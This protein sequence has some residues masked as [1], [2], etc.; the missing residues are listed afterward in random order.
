MIAA[1]SAP[2]YID[3]VEESLQTVV[4]AAVKREDEQEFA[5]LNGKTYCFAKM[6]PEE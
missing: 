3:I 6:L 5:R 4:Q 1:D 2:K